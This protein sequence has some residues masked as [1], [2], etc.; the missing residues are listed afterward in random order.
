MSYNFNFIDNADINLQAGNGGNGCTSFRR[1]KFIEFGGPDG[2][3][4]GR[5]GSIIFISDANINTLVGFRYQKHF[6]ATN[7][8]GGSGR[9]RFGA[10][11]EDLVIRV[12]LGTSIID[13]ETS[14]LLHEF[15]HDEEKHILLEGGRG[16]IGNSFFKTSTNRAPRKS[17]PGFLG[18]NKWVTLNMKLLAD[19][20]LLGKPNVGKSSF[21]S[22]TTN[23]NTKIAN[24]AFTTLKP[25]LGVIEIDNNDAF[26]V[27]DLPG[28]IEGAAEGRGLGINFLKHVE[29]CEILLHV[30][31]IYNK[32]LEEIIYDYQMI[33]HEL[34]EYN[35]LLCSKQE[36]IVFNKIDLHQNKEALLALKDGFEK[37]FNKEIYL[38]STKTKEGIKK[39]T[40][41]LNM[42]IKVKNKKKKEARIVV[43]Y[44]P[45]GKFAEKN[46]KY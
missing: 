25:S 45:V 34:K 36:I 1:E 32:E 12:P 43:P 2:G 20:G 14:E 13:R 19:V 6:R 10:A 9:C 39:L 42:I 46:R 44:K 40:L 31:D 23:S 24:Y 41:D 35:E 29:K 30:I 7:G 8:G 37:N 16:G 27:A 15:T 28:L 17:T 3:N 33:W 38:I 4:G 21:L 22:S 11:G 18:V 26:V 5:G